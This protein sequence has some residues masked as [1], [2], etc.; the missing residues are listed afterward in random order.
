MILLQKNENRF[1]KKQ[2]KTIG[3]FFNRIVIIKELNHIKLQISTL[4]HK[5]LEVSHALYIMNNY[6]KL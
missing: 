5:N 1:R 6:H 4:S 3:C 2:R